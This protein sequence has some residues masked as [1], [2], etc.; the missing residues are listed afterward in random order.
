V[1][2]WFRPLAYA[3]ILLREHGIPCLFYPDLYGCKYVDKNEAGEEVEVELVGVPDLHT[4]SRI[5]KF[6]AHGIQR[7]YFDHPNC[8]GWTREGSPENKGSGLA[9]VMS[10]GEAGF[11]TMEIGQRHAGSVFTDALGHRKEEVVID[12]NGWADFPCEARSVSIWT[13]GYIQ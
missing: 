13:S 4:I 10:N 2:Y 6:L 12:D 3:L 7:D 9:V 1:E 11:K 8:I 5:R